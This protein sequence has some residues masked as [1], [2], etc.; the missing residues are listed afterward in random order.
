MDRLDAEQAE[1]YQAHLVLPK[2]GVYG[3]RRL[4][5]SRV[6]LVGV[7]GLGCPAALYLAAAGV[8]TLGLLDDDVVDRTNLQRQ[9]LFGTED[10]GEAKVLVAQKR[11]AGINPDVD[12]E[13]L[14]T[15]LTA[16]NAMELVAGWDLVIDGSDNFATRYVVNDACV[17]ARIPLVTGSIYQYEG[18]VTVI[19]PPLSPCYRCLFRSPPPEQPACRDAGVLAPL[20][21]IVGSL[22]A[23]EAVKLLVGGDTALIGRLLLFDAQESSSRSVRVKSDPSCPLCGEAPTIDRPTAVA[24]CRDPDS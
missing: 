9:V 1:R 10:I 7:G 12:L 15:R 13:T 16:S 3:Q 5:D 6:L 2:I 23:A 17:L 18:Q 14:E 21:G 11:L 19:R 8:G 24:T 4:L 22:L 20:P